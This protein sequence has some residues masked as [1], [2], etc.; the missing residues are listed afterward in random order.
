M[1]HYIYSGNSINDCFK[2][3]TDI[4]A[5]FFNNKDIFFIFFKLMFSINLNYIIKN[6]NF[7]NFSL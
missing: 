6:K 3:C 2:I 4:I 7:Q 5:Y 1:I